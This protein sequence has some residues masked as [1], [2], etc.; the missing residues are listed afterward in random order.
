LDER[1][2]TLSRLKSSFDTRRAYISAKL[3]TLV[4]SQI[5]ALRTKSDMPRQADL[6]RASEMLQSRISVLETPGAA[7][8]T[9]DTLS[10]IA[11]AFKVGVIVKFVPFSEMLAWENSFSQDQFDVIKID[12]DAQFLAA[13]AGPGSS[14]AMVSIPAE[15]QGYLFIGL[16]NRTTYREGFCNPMVPAS[17]VTQPTG[18]ASS[19]FQ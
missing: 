16:A 6:A 8:A 15:S 11:A 10:R 12:Q 3:G 2:T 4:P 19:F 7:N 18:A 17:I 13:S 9:L 1:S 14:M 5:R